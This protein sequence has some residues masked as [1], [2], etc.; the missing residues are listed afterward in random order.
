[1]IPE[2]QTSSTGYFDAAWFDAV[3]PDAGQ[4]KEAEK[5]CAK[6][7]KKNHVPVR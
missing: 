5:L 2:R 3:A 4:I 1:M 6:L 7:K